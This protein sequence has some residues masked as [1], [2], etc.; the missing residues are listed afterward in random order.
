MTDKIPEGCNPKL[1]KHAPFRWHYESRAYY[2]NGS[3][4]ALNIKHRPKK[5]VVKKRRH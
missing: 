4:S 1:Y 3:Q 2:F 5:K